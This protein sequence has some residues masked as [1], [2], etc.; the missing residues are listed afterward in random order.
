MCIRFSLCIFPFSCFSIFWAS[1]VATSKHREVSVCCRNKQQPVQIEN[2]LVFVLSFACEEF[3]FHIFFLFVS[4]FVLFFFIEFSPPQ[5]LDISSA[6]TS[7]SLFFLFSSFLLMEC[8][9]CRLRILFSCAIFTVTIS[10]CEMF[11][12]WNQQRQIMK[13]GKR[14]RKKNSSLD[15][16]KKNCFELKGI[17][18]GTVCKLMGVF[19][20]FCFRSVTLC[21]SEWER[22]GE[23]RVADMKRG[24]IREKD[25]KLLF[26]FLFIDNVTICFFLRNFKFAASVWGV[27][28][29]FFF[30]KY[31]NKYRHLFALPLGNFQAFSNLLACYVH[32]VA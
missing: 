19:F 5:T 13:L 22:E 7:Y 31:N 15:E 25:V 27:I 16:N 17:T 18:I 21:L 23:I 26:S 1:T 14:R 3:E 30:S 8:F 4:V 11:C 24:A 32:V 29:D 12:K 28:S 9:C 20:T 2:Q 6:N 10:I